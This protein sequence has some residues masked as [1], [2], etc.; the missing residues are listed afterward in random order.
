M[1]QLKGVHKVGIGPDFDSRG[2][3]QCGKICLV[4]LWILYGHSLVRA[5]GRK[6]LRS[7]R[8]VKNHLVPAEI[9]CRIVGG[10]QGVDV[11][12]AYERLAAEFRSGQ[13]GVAFIKDFAGGL[14]LEYLVNA[15]GAAELK[16][17]PVIERVAHR[18]LD[19]V[20]PFLEFL[21]G[22]GFA[23]GDVIFRD[24][25]RPHRA[26]FVMVARLAVHQ[27]EL[28][29]VAEL[30]VFCYLLRREMAMIIDDRHLGRVPVI[31]LFSRTVG[32]HKIFADE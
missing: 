13:L 2:L 23:A 15:E 32:E 4:G 1:A 5:P 31:Q 27:P 30:D 3:F 11:E 8:V 12:F 10:T 21:P 16:V 26:P 6:D 7:E 14:G 28:R 9:I 17:G 29:D 25:V 20:R 24:T 22:R 18:V 19:G